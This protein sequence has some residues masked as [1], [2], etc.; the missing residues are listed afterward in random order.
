MTLYLIIIA[1][2]IV[3]IA[4]FNLIFNFFELSALYIILSPI[5]STVAVIAL[6][7]LIAFLAHCIPDKKTDPFKKPFYV[8]YK[9]R[10]FYDK[11]GIK[12]WKDYLPDL[13]GI[14]C[15]FKKGKIEQPKN[16]QYIMKYLKESCYGSL[17]HVISAFLGF[18]IIFI[19]PLKYALIFGVPIGI[20][21]MVLN[22]MPFFSLRYNRA[23]LQIVYKRLEKQQNAQSI[24]LSHSENSTVC[25]NSKN[26]E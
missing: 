19:H 25:Q 14:C 10:K 12:K 3:L 22:L 13:G 18:V 9:E 15:G 1:I 8:D 16:P 24:E 17:G 21:N 20:V 26:N 11:L 6:D 2:T 5:I 4:S 7:G 23:A